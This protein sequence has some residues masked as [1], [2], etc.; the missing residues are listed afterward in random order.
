HGTTVPLPV[1]VKVEKPLAGA[2]TKDPKS[3]LPAPIPI[4]DH[5]QVSCQT[6]RLHATVCEACVPEAVLVAI[7]MPGTSSGT[8]HSDSSAEWLC[9]SGKTH[10]ALSSICC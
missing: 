2:R 10:S 4:T 3:R 5:R 6:K 7:E 1:A 8:K 9:C